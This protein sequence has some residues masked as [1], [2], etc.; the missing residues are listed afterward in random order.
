MF[1]MCALLGVV[2]TPEKKGSLLLTNSDDD[3]RLGALQQR[4]K[5]LEDSA[6][7]AVCMHL[8]KDSLSKGLN[9]ESE[10]KDLSLSRP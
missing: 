9:P 10:T 5:E 2:G 6:K 7:T 4:T 8:K 3:V 1:M